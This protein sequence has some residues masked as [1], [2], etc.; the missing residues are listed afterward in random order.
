M[1]VQAQSHLARMNEIMVAHHG[2]S[3]GADARR[4]CGACL[5]AGID[6]ARGYHHQNFHGGVLDLFRL[7]KFSYYF[8][9]SQRPI[10]EGPM[11]FIASF[12]SFL[13]PPSV[14]VFSNCEQVR[15]LRDGKEI[16]VQA[17]DAGH[18]IAHP[19][20]TFQTGRLLSERT[21]L[22]MNGSGGIEPAPVE[23]KAEGLVGGRV[24]ATHV[25]HPP[26]VAKKL[27]LEADLCDV[28]LVADRSDWVR[29]YAKICDA[30]DAICPLADDLITFRARG[31][32]EI[33][34]DGNSHVRANPMRAE[35]G[36]A[37]ALVRATATAGKIIVN[38][39]A[40]GLA[41]GE[42]EIVSRAPANV[43]LLPAEQ[44]VSAPARE[45]SP[46]LAAH[47]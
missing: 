38:A 44:H 28:P 19:P 4:L 43:S 26:G 22:F 10:D 24:V 6:H 32:G 21:T 7:P 40:F 20:F 25:V 1:L 47:P 9:Q 36:I 14:M 5:W 33:I 17:C 34:G 11:V 37:T 16:G 2:S 30:R 13:S 41:D 39:T 35:A 45:R 31:E 42:I 46:R 18:R 12:A 15:L 29:V 3:S 8:F 23:L 27:L